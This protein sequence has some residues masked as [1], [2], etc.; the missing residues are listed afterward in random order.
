MFYF[1]FLFCYVFL[2]PILVDTVIFFL[3]KLSPIVILGI[4]LFDHY[5]ILVGSL[6]SLYILNTKAQFFEGWFNNLGLLNI[7]KFGSIIL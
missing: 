5:N 2:L 6:T 1:L 4:R 3:V 7:L